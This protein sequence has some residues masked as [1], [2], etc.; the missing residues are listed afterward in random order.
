[1]N[2]NVCERQIVTVFVLADLFSVLLPFSTHL[3]NKSIDTDSAN[4]N[5]KFLKESSI[6][7]GKKAGWLNFPINIRCRC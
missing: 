4:R 6:D 1:M 5:L 3:P 2:Q 7:K